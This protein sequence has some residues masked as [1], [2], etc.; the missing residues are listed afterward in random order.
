MAP[1]LV[2]ELQFLLG[3]FAGVEQIHPSAWSEAAS[4][5]AVAKGDPELAG[6]LLLQR[7]AEQP[8]GGERFDAVN[9]FVRDAATDEVLLYSF[10]SA[11]YPPEP[12]ARGRLQD[13]ELVLDRRTERGESQTV[14]SATEAGYAWSKK[15]RPDADS[16]WQPVVS[17]DLRRVDVAGSD[18]AGEPKAEG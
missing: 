5:E 2:D 17:G 13:S 7:H 8:S 16:P 14:Y 6:A 4:A 3:A 1:S 10:D 18:S 12:P 11:G 9:V 15:F